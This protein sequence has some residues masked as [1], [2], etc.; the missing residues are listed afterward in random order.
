MRA[1]AVAAALSG[2]TSV[3]ALNS[4]TCIAAEPMAA[5]AAYV[6][7]VGADVSETTQ[8]EVTDRSSD[9][10]ETGSLPAPEASEPQVFRDYR[11]GGPEG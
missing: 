8:T 2:L 4:T 1:F 10:A 5:G 11:I 9:P 7:Q 3:G 6:Q